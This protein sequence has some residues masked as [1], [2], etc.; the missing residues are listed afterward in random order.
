MSKCLSVLVLAAAW[1]VVAPLP[2]VAQE[3]VTTYQLTLRDGSRIYG[4]VEGQTAE[5][6]EFRTITGSL[7]TARTGDVVSLKQ[8]TGSMVAGEFLPDDLNQTRLFFAPTAR[9][10]PKGQVSFGTYEFLM[11]FV[12]VGVTDRFSMGGGTPLVFGFDESERP[13]WLTPKYQLFDRG[14][15]QAAAGLFHIVSGSGNAGI[16]YGVVTAGG[17]AQSLSVGAGLGY[18]D[19]G[20]RSAVVMVGADRRV[21]RNLKVLTENYVWK[22]GGVISA[23]VRFIG[24]RLSADLG[25]AVPLGIDGFIVAP[26]VNFVYM[27]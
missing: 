2:V 24:E 27:F 26:V 5:Q 7:I 10:L 13:F 18:E 12:Q 17:A 22:G 6:I 4:V 11:P 9:S 1:T 14:G 25:L 8:T 20:G 3:S 15:V 23:G 21:S 19:G 16:A